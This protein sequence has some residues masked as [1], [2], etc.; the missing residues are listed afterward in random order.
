MTDAQLAALLDEFKRRHEAGERPDPAVFLE[1]AGDSPDDFAVL[2]DAYLADCPAPALPAAEL[3]RIA[4]SPLFDPPAWR[5]L[6][7]AAREERGILRSDVVRRLTS[8]L[9]LRVEQQDRVAEHLHDLETGVLPPSGVSQ[10]VVDAFDGIFGGIGAALERTRLISPHT[11]LFSERA[12]ARDAAAPI[13]APRHQP[14]P[15]AEVDALF[16]GR[17]DA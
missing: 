16:F 13:A 12:F 3:D 5:T 8:A 15:D 17:G 2:L 7:V 10:R 9:G 4:S 1:R 6:L 11:K 14:E